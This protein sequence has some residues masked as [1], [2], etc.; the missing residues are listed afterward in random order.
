MQVLSL[1]VVLAASACTCR[2]FS[3]RSASPV[4]SSVSR[5]VASS[6]T[7][8]HDTATIEKLEATVAAQA[9]RLADIERYFVTGTWGGAPTKSLKELCELTHEACEVMQPLIKAFYAKCNES[10]GTAKLKADATFF[11][12]ADGIVQHLMVEYFLAGNKFGQIVGEEDETEVN[13]LTKPYTVDDL[14]VP[15]EFEGLVETTRNKIIQLAKKVDS[16]SYKGVT[17]F[18]DPIDGTREFA[19]GKGEFCSILVGYNNLIGQPVAG[20]MYR[21][22][23]SPPTWAAGAKSENC[24]MGQLDKAKTPNHKVREMLKE[25]VL[26]PSS[27]PCV[28]PSLCALLLWPLAA[29]A[30]R[31]CSCPTAST[32][33]FSS[34]PSR[35]WA[36]RRCPRTRP[37]TAR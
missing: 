13:I 1:L 8:L 3:L 24:V 26:R 37:A 20:I 34:K 10:F 32:P 27:S 25:T 18:V 9:K 5:R 21:P 33:R 12:I 29:A 2:G 30:N 22:L 14:V 28:T 6:S 4:V 7:K 17:V 19:T 36:T 23:T 35:R 11:S 31:A 15:E 16:N